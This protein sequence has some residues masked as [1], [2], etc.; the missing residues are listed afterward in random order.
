MRWLRR[1]GRDRPNPRRT[2]RTVLTVLAGLVLA[3]ILAGEPQI[4]LDTGPDGFLPPGDSALDGLHERERA[5]GGDPV[6]LVLESDRPGVLT[7]PDILPRLVGLEGELARNPDVTV[8]YGPGTILNQVAGQAQNMLAQISG[9]RDGIRAVAEQQARRGG[10]GDAAV[11]TAVRNSTAEFDRRYG[12]LIVRGLPAGLPTLRNPDFVRTV[13]FD[14]DGEPRA[15]WNH[16]VPSQHAIAILVRPRSGLGQPESD[17]IVAGVRET[18]DRA[19]LP[20][21]RATVTGVPAVTSALADSIRSDGPLLGAAAV[22]LVGVV[23]WRASAIRS[24]RRRLVPL[25]SALGGTA[26]TLGLAGW[27]GITLSLGAVALLPV[28]LGIGGFYALYLLHGAAPRRIAVVAC[29]SAAGFAALAASST[30]FVRELGLA[31]ALGIVCSFGLGMLL[32]RLL[33]AEPAVEPAAESSVESAAESSPDF[34]AESSPEAVAGPSEGPGGA[35]RRRTRVLVAAVVAA[36]V[37]WAA[38]PVLPVQADPQR[39]AAGLGA[40]DD[41]AVAERVLGSSGE[42][43]VVLRGPDVATPEALAWARSA[44]QAVTVAHGDRVRPVVSYPDVLAFLGPRPSSDQIRAGLDLVPPYLTDAVIHREHQQ[45]LLTFGIRLG[46]LGEQARLLDAVRAALPP[47]PDGYVIDVV[48]MPVAAARAVDLVS[49]DRYLGNLLG[50][51]AAGLVLGMGLRRR[52]DAIRAVAAAALA[53][54]W[55]L[56][57]VWVTGQELSPMTVAL[58]SLTAAVGCEFTVLLA[59]ARRR[60]DPRPRRAV[61]TAAVTATIGSAVLVFSGL[62]VVRQFGLFLAGSVLLSLL[63]SHLVIRLLPERSRTAHPA[64]TDPAESPTPIGAP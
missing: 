4:R 6:V 64:G 8:V 22:V 58:G 18:A 35:P 30:P 9:R 13:L 3:G 45:A 29:A 40:L 15:Q 61:V 19:G 62:V 46:D 2:F 12:A 48:G 57:L 14:A 1:S 36:A 59:D 26:L 23:L 47:A 21:V 38:L 37:G 31:L 24:R 50:I 52:S 41:A 51:A 7:G 49:T 17:R 54:G 43:S 11:A 32:V 56:A 33:G 60:R 25:L 44:Q 28:L 42:V 10:A 34:A 20:G 55:G 63:A 5:F 53:T 16:V 39:L 27:S